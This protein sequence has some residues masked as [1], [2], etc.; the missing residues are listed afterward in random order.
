MGKEATHYQPR[1]Y[2]VTAESLRIRQCLIDMIRPHDQ[3]V[4]V[5]VCLEAFDAPRPSYT[6]VYYH[7]QALCKEEILVPLRRGV[8][9]LH[10]AVRGAIA[11]GPS[12]AAREASPAERGCMHEETGAVYDEPAPVPALADRVFALEMRLGGLEQ[13]LDM[14]K[15]LFL[16]GDE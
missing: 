12:T 9:G 3:G 11:P 13:E 1:R 4:Q 16:A 10:R 8:Y 5:K 6:A 15:Q 14:L 2:P 7:L